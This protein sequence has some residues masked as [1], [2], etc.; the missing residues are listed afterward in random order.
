MFQAPYKQPRP[1]P[2]D[3]AFYSL[4]ISLAGPT[5]AYTNLLAVGGEGWHEHS[6]TAPFYTQGTFAGTRT[7]ER[8]NKVQPRMCCWASVD[9]GTAPWLKRRV[10]GFRLSKETGC[11]P[12]GWCFDQNAGAADSQALNCQIQYFG[13]G[14]EEEKQKRAARR[15][16]TGPESSTCTGR[17]VEKT[18]QTKAQ[19]GRTV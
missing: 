6:G 2:T 12:P 18:R 8:Q 10:R 1:F 15:V 19:W 9:E 7:R 14:E 13:P 3:K 4:L 17:K 16:S 11:R 5:M